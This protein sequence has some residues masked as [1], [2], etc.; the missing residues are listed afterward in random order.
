MR[1]KTVFQSVVIFSAA[2]VGILT[3][4]IGASVGRPQDEELFV[5]RLSPD[6]RAEYGSLR[7]LMTRAERKELWKLCGE[8]NR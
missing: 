7:Y 3:V 1:I 6:L 5:E 8:K 2:V 4:A